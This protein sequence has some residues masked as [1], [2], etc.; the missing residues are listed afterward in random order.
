MSFRYLTIDKTQFNIQDF[1]LLKHKFHV[2][3][4]GFRLLSIIYI[5]QV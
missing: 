4:Y 1:Q 5:I 3:D 2:K